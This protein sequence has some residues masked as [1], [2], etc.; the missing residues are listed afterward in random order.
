MRLTVPRRSSI[1]FFLALAVAV[2]VAALLSP[3]TDLQ[4]SYHH[5]ADQRSW[6]GIPHFGD[7]A[8]NLAFLLAG[9]P[10]APPTIT[11]LPTMPASF[12]TASR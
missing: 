5:F 3:R 9:L 12:G 4:P 6:L 7:V 11:W 2:A 8:S 10:S 1:W